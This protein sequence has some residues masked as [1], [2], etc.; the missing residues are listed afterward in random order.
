M[1]QSKTPQPKAPQSQSSSTPASPAGGD[2]VKSSDAI[3]KDTALPPATD[4][5]SLRLVAL[6]GDDLTVIAAHLQDA[7]GRVRDMA[8]VPKEQR[9]ALLLNRFNWAKMPTTAGGGQGSPAPTIFERRRCAL[10]FEHVRAAKVTGF[11]QANKKQVL[12][13]LTIRFE[14]L[15][16]GEPDGH[17]ALTFASGAE[18]RLDVEVIEAELTD[19]GAGW[20]TAVKPEHQ[21]G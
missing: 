10:R 19:I 4:A 21:D 17:I 16:E 14:P 3:V 11:S 20:R 1:S 13:L 15:R 5:T 9:F 6:D 12:S 8:F 2:S 18:I 7:V